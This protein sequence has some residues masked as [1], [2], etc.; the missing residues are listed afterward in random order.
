MWFLNVFRNMILKSLDFSQNFSH[1]A[2]LREKRA[3]MAISIISCYFLPFLFFIC[4]QMAFPKSIGA[5]VFGIAGAAI[6]TLILYFQLSG[7]GE[8]KVRYLIKE[9]PA[10]SEP[11]IRVAEAPEPILGFVKDVLKSA[12]KQSLPDLKAELASQQ[13]LFAEELEKKNQALQDLQKALDS[14]KLSLSSKEAETL[15]LQKELEDVKF[16]LYTLLR[17][18]SYRDSKSEKLA[19]ASF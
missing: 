11:K 4:A 16:E 9:V 7:Q 10:Q 5:F 1:T 2:V 17:I 13:A 19:A 8:E 12:P 14:V 18:E 3:N 6:G 15:R